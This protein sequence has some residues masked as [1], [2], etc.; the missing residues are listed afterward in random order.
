MN[1][2]EDILMLMNRNRGVSMNIYLYKFYDDGKVKNAGSK[3]P[4][5]IYEI[6]NNL[7]WN[8]YGL[9][10]PKESNNL[11]RILKGHIKLK[12]QLKQLSKLDV[13]YVLYQHPMMGTF[14][15][16]YLMKFFNRN[17]IKV[18]TLIHDIDS[19]RFYS[20]FGKKKEKRELATLEQSSHVICHN[21]KMKDYLI[22]KGVPKNK[23]ICL[24]CFDYLSDKNDLNR[25]KNDKNYSVAVAGNLNPIKSKY[26]YKMIEENPSLQIDLYGIGYEDN[27]NYRNVNY[28]GSFLPEELPSNINSAFGL[29]WDGTDINTCCGEFGNYLRFNN[30]HKFSL[31]MATGIP[32]VVWDQ[33]AIADFVEKNNLGIRVS[34][35][36]DLDNKLSNISIESYNDMVQNVKLIQEKV[37]DG[38]YFK[39][40]LSKIMEL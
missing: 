3:A 19:L 37:L 11:F 18:I 40:V 24:D 34:D 8:N 14:Y 7:G 10:N 30:P 27:A 21:D 31:Y 22:S 16:L 26:I 12:K 28:H 13:D 35:L 38:G 5:D 25:E 32:V 2:E 6:C 17:N 36:N 15:N 23:I 39:T 20:S 29:V 9:I 1:L 33:S 4:N